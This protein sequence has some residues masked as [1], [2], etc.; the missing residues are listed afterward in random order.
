L[1]NGDLLERL[2]RLDTCAVSD[3]MD[4]LQLRGTVTRLSAMWDCG[5]IAGRAMT[6]LLG[7]HTGKPS[8]RHLGSAAIEA[9]GPEHVIVIQ[10]NGRADVA[11]WGGLLSTAAKQKGIAGTI[12]DGACRDVD[13]SRMRGYPVYALK[14][15]PTTAR[16]RI[17]EYSFNEPVTIEN[18]RVEPGDYVLAD[19]SGIV[20]VSARHIEQVLAK[21]EAIAAKEA[22]MAADILAGKSIT[23]VMG[24]QY[25]TMLKKE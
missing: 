25:E 19:G 4:A 1:E 9:A 11:G 5:K 3:A 2:K 8:V 7:P 15:V 6:V 13:E 10:H 23:E 14:A 22:A 18:V 12:I 16:G 20:F 17:E 21:A 24:I